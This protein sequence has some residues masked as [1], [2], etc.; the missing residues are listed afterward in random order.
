MSILIDTHCHIDYFGDPI[1]TAK[2]YEANNLSCVMVSM[3]PSHY[4]MAL[5]HLKPFGVI[6]PALGMHP[7]RAKEGRN[8]IKQFL[9]MVEGVEFIGEIGLDHSPAGRDSKTIQEEVLGKILPSIGAGKFV[10][11]HSRDAHNPLAEM[12]NTYSV[13]PV[14]FHYFT[15]GSDSA[16]KLVS[17]GHFFSVNIKMLKGRHR[18]L[19]DCLPKE[20]ILVESDGPFLTKEPIRAVKE[21]YALL[22]NVWGMSECAVI[23]LLKDNFNKCRTVT[24]G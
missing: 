9:G 12:L 6:R 22:G 4:Q 11:V 5:S 20:R 14:C 16:L 21:A 19:L 15:G 8:E 18:T 13:G 17:A 24:R 23:K 7:L 10:S 1:E 3:L 2:S